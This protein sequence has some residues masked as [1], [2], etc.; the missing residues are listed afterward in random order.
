VIGGEL[1]ETR[2]QPQLRERGRRRRD[3][4]QHPVDAAL[5]G[6]APVLLEETGRLPARS[7]LLLLGSVLAAGLLTSLVA[8]AAALRQPLLGAL[9]SE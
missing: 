1:R 5:L 9:R 8:T 2:R 4:A 7:L 3:E 6:I